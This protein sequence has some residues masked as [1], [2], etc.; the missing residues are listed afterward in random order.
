MRRGWVLAALAAA[1]CAAPGAR[2][3]FDPDAEEGIHA[4]VQIEWW[5][6]WGF[7]EDDHGGRWSL[8]SSFFRTWRQDLAL[9]RY[10]LY[11]LTDL[12]SGARTTRS[13]AGEEALA[14]AA[15]VTGQKRF[16]PPHQV[17]P[18]HP[19]ETPGSL[20]L[21][22]GDD[23]LERVGDR[24][25]RLK[26]QDAD[27][28][29]KAVT[30]P[31]AVEGSGLTGIRKPDDMHYYSIPRLEARGSLRGRPVRGVFWYDHQWGSSWVGA[32]LGWDWWGL[33]LD[34]GRDLNAYALRDFRTGTVLRSVATLGDRVLPLSAAP[35]EHWSSPAG[36][37]YPVRWSLKAG[38]L[39]LEVRPLFPDRETAV[40]GT[41]KSIWEGPVHAGGSHTGRGFQ[42][43]VGYSWNI[44]K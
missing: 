11:D 1:G 44:G 3:A 16:Q 34:D 21:R 12:H 40:L 2:W 31:M 35:L 43:L 19:L 18:G 32:G 29:L 20:R 41:L 33:H 8:F 37:R 10:Q 24:I 30:E 42:E 9:M 4:D 28:T 38:D 7:L 36:V 22:Y 15:K 13:A 23:F 25:Y 5:Y 17:I 14:V 6:H 39:D 26:V 27:L